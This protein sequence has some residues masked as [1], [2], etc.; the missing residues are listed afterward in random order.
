MRGPKP[1]SRN[2]K[3]ITGNPG[4]RRIGNEPEPQLAK[5]FRCPSWIGKHGR[6]LWRK[7]APELL[8]AGV[9][10]EW[11]RSSFET[12]CSNY[13]LL[14]MAEAELALAG[15][16][17]KDDRGGIKKHPA[18]SIF[19]AAGDTYAKHAEL[20]GL[21]PISRQRLDVRVKEEPTKAEKFM[22]SKNGRWPN[23]R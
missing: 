22:M 1:K 8:K 18:A 21:T 20:F 4:G 23:D 6:E 19:K 17:V 7:I 5:S 14:R 10:T 15:L 9:L 13:H 11:D 3:L 16:T 2:Q 12:M